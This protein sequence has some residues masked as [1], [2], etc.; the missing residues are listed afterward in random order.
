MKEAVDGSVINA[1]KTG[2]VTGWVSLAYG[3]AEKT[4]WGSLGENVWESGPRGVWETDEGSE[5]R[6]EAGDDGGAIEVVEFWIEIAGAP[7]AMG[8]GTRTALPIRVLFFW[9]PKQEFKLQQFPHL[10]FCKSQKHQEIRFP[11]L[12]HQ[13]SLK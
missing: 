4:D 1:E 10:L 3:P 11:L 8:S 6:N 2:G 9:D 13:S 5:W 7:D 12:F